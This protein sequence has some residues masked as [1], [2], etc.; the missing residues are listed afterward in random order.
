M[1][2]NNANKVILKTQDL[3]F[4]TQTLSVPVN[5]P[6]QVENGFLKQKKKKK[7]HTKEIFLKKII[8]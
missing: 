6:S 4:Y 8:L 2:R 1:G 3:S 7:K 5:T